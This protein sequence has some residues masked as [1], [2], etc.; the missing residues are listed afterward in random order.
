MIM[1]R[2]MKPWM[3]VLLISIAYVGLTLARHGGDPL[4][5]ALVGTRYS[6][7]DPQGTQG[8]DGQF[9]Y[10]IARDPLGGWRHCDVPA[11]RCQRILYPLLAWVL[12]LGQPVAVPWTLI[13]VNL[14]AVAVGTWFTER[15]LASHGVSRWYAIS[16]G[17]Y[18]GIIAGLRLNLSEP[19]AYGLVQGGLWARAERR[20]NLAT[21]LFVLAAL[22]KE[23]A[24]I[25]VAGVLLYLMFEGRWRDMLSLGLGVAVPFVA[26]QGTL[27]IWLGQPGVGSGGAMATPFRWF[28]FAGLLHIATV[29]W[30]AF[31][32]LLA[33]EGPLFV[34]PTVWASTTSVRDHLRGR[35]HPWATLL[36]V[37]A[38]VLPFLPFST[39]REPLAMARLA[40]GLVAATLLYGALR[41]SQR[42]LNF[43]FS[44]LATLALLINESQLPV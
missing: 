7:D 4:A 27:W 19:L 31:W 23:T 21:A 44:W 42:V 32:L 12:A 35:L 14:A 28:P 38:A 22:A 33:V 36:L 17:L 16:Y 25:A 39:W 1:R 13:L 41:H 20:N 34:F 6:Q 8:Y 24:L 30:P 10:F 18:G 26:W 9:A 29:S 15:V 11:Y 37:Q 40:T 3:L 5:F 2:G 43:S